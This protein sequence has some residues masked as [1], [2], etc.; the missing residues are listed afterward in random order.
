VAVLTQTLHIARCDLC[1]LAFDEPGDVWCW[2]ETP[3]LALA[4]VAENPDWTVL[5]DGTVV[6]PRSD[7]EHDVVR[8]A[9]SPTTLHPTSDAMR[10]TYEHQRQ[11]KGPS[12]PWPVFDARAVAEKW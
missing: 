3:E 10:V 2:D 7:V 12:R 9:E 4:Q 1:L 8:G 11:V 5:P 6:C